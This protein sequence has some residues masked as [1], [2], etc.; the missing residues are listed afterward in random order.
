MSSKEMSPD[1]DKPID[2]LAQDALNRRGFV[3]KV[4]AQIENYPMDGKTSLV[5]GIDAKWGD[6]KTS[7]INCLKT[8]YLDKDKTF[9]YMDFN[10]GNGQRR[11]KYLM[12][13]GI[14]LKPFFIN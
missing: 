9:S 14:L 1:L 7:V 3:E 13:F 10:P 11:I 12:V 4:F 2:S 5:I 6:G 8:D